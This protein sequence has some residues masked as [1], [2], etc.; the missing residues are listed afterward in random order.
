MARLPASPPVHSFPRPCATW[1]CPSTS[2]SS[3]EVL[4]DAL[5]ATDGP[6]EHDQREKTED[7]CRTKESMYIYYVYIY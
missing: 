7:G 3:F 1:E 5:E 2:Q 4:L 6:L